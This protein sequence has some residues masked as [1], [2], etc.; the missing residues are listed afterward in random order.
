MTDTLTLFHAPR[1]R[2]TGVITLLR[3]LGAPYELHVLDMK[4]GDHRQPDYLAVNPLG[5]VPAIRHGEAIVTEQVAIYIYLADAFPAAGLAPA[6]GDPLRGPYLRWLALYGSAYEP[7]VVDLAKKHEPGPHAMSPYGTF[8]EVL[9]LV[10]AQL[11]KGPYLFG[12]RFTAAD[13][14]WGTALRWTTGFGLVPATPEIAA[15]I[16]NVCNRP[17]IAEAGKIDAELTAAQG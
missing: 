11:A 14:L 15:Y 6:I 13:I 12:E 16:E 3:E 5:K 4:A 9:A 17:S 1:T 8:E 2:S 7:A 10:K